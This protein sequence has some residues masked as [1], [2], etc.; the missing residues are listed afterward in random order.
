MKHLSKYIYLEQIKKTAL[1]ENNKKKYPIKI[2][3]RI[4]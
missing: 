2:L 4:F 1:K 3:S